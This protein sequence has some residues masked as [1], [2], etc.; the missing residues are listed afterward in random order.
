MNVFHFLSFL[1][2]PLPKVKSEACFQ[3]IERLTLCYTKK[4]NDQYLE[5]DEKAWQEKKGE[6]LYFHQQQ[7]SI[8]F[9]SKQFSKSQ[10]NTWPVVIFYYCFQLKWTNKTRNKPPFSSLEH[11]SSQFSFSHVN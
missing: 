6:K 4:K 11:I 9:I 1:L 8:P 10:T 5:V 2:C 3:R 7:A